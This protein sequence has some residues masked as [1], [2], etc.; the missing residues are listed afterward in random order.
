MT[1]PA[2]LVKR[3]FT[4]EDAAAYLSIGKRTMWRLIADGEVRKT[5]IG[6]RTLVDRADLDAYVDRVK[7]SA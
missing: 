2:D 6:S 5:P 4:V 3:L 7:R 1:A